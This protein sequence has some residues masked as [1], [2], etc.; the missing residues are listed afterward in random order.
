MGLPGMCAM[1]RPGRRGKKGSAA[2]RHYVCYC[3]HNKQINN[4]LFF[5]S[6]NGYDYFESEI[7]KLNKYYVDDVEK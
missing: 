1:L 4:I 3:I 6:K 2:W 7:K 5:S